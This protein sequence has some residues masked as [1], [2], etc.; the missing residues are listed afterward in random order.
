MSGLRGEEQKEKEVENR[1]MRMK[2]EDIQLS[3][4]IKIY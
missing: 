4:K 2:Y 3:Q 1:S